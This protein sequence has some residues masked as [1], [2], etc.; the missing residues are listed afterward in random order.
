MAL[1]DTQCAS[2][3]NKFSEADSRK[4]HSRTMSIEGFTTFLM[5]SDNSGFDERQLRVCDNMSRPLCEYYISSSHNVSPSE[6]P[7]LLHA[8]TA[9][10]DL[11]RGRAIEG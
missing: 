1:S 9:P 11:P 10:L 3:F 8:N 5:S 2:L 6:L 4:P 7:I